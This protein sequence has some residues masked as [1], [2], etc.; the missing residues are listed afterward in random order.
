MT[1]EHELSTGHVVELPLRIEGRTDGVCLPVPVDGLHEHLPAGLSPLRLTRRYGVLTL[2][3]Q[4]YTTVENGSLAPYDEL[5]VQIPAVPEGSSSLPL[6]SALRHATSGYVWYMPVSTDAAV[7]LG[8]LW[9]FPKVVG[10]VT[11]ERRRDRTTASVAVDGES[12]LEL[13]VAS[14]RG[15]E[16]SVSGTAFTELD[17]ELTRVRTESTGR[18]GA[19]PL[20]TAFAL[21]FGEHDVA[22]RMRAL[23][24]VTRRA[25]L[26]LS[27]ECTY[28]FWAGVPIS[29]Q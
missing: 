19:W 26:R 7:A 14:A 3:L 16:T 21:R 2:L 15:V 8:D 12:L 6:Y 18:I 25:V 11:I 5:S 20:S 9:G 1:R 4:D 13:T 23:E 17:G 24:P 29:E 10:D 28:E 22:E 27:A